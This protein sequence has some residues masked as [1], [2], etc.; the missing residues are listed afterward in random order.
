MKIK[1]R[2][3][4][5]ALNFTLC[6]VSLLVLPFIDGSQSWGQYQGRKNTGRGAQKGIRRP[7]K[8][9]LIATDPPLVLNGATLPGRPGL[10]WG[11]EA[12]YRLQF[13]DNR[14]NPYGL[15]KAR[16]AF[17]NIVVGAGKP[18]PTAQTWP[19][20]S[21]GANFEDNNSY[22]TNSSIGYDPDNF[23]NSFHQRWHC[24]ADHVPCVRGAYCYDYTLSSIHAITKK[25]GKTGRK[26]L[27]Q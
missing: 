15:G 27:H 19:D 16:E 6:I 1:K 8:A 22:I 17:S 21:V 2:K 24:M 26:I 23:V 18:S 3:F 4:R 13:R 12:H 25:M 20:S 5:A 10:W 11:H 7:V 9:I 14:N